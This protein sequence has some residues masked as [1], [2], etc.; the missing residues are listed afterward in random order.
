MK[1]KKNNKKILL[2]I[3]FVIVSL[4]LYNSSILL[5]KELTD[6]DELWNFNFAN[7][8]AN[9]LV[10]Y[11]DFNMIQMPLLPMLA[12]IFLKIF[13][14]EVMVMRF[15]AVCLITY[16]E[17][18]VFF[19]LD[20]LKVKDYIKYLI[21]IFICFIITPYIAIDYNYMI[22]AIL[23]TIIYIEIKSYLR[24]EKILVYN[25]K[26]DFIIGILA[27]LCFISKQSTGMCVILVAVLYK[28]LEIRSKKDLIEF[29]KIVFTRGIGA[30][31]PIV[32]ILLY[33]IINGAIYDFISYCILGIKTFSNY[34]PYINLLKNS[35]IFIKILSILIP[36][37]LILDLSL[38]VKKKKKIL[39]ILSV[40]TIASMIVIYPIADNI[41]FLIGIF[42][43]FISLAYFTDICIDK[44]LSNENIKEFLGSFF[45]IA[46]LLISLV[47]LAYSVNI[48]VKSNKNYELKHFKSTIM[49]ENYIKLVKN[50]GEYIN[51]SQKKVYILDATASVYMIPI[52]KY[53]KDYDMFL[54]GNLGKDGEEG[55]IEKLK[56]EENAIIL[57]MNSKYKRNWQNPEKVRSYIINNKEK[58]G[59]IGN[60]EIYE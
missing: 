60:F 53:N 40:Y 37:I 22:L 12:S 16:I 46:T 30:L 10:P 1:V 51:S 11:K 41:H 59:E 55:Q 23:L 56:N 42:P 48:Y 29:I 58:T 17:I 2:K 35:K 25:L 45:K 32:I 15:L 26:I 6:L 4:L 20:K 57:I 31:I 52:D 24:N 43:G 34:I 49:N 50:I 14:Q 9:G 28:C 8:M 33:L 21:L 47:C 54:K 19:I 7:N 39:L 36:V 27:G 3:I 5:I 44:I 18:T 13:G 38:Y